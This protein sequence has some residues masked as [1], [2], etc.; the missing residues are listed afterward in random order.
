MQA[1]DGRSW[2]L[3]FEPDGFLPADLGADPGA[4]AGVE[5]VLCNSALAATTVID[6]PGLDSLTADAGR[7]TEELLGL[8][9]ASHR[10][11][12]G[13][14]A[15]LFLVPGLTRDDDRR[16]R[17]M[18]A[19]LA[20]TA[21]ASGF[22]PA[23][24]LAVVSRADVLEGPDPVDLSSDADP[25]PAARE[26]ADRYAERLR[27]VAAG[28]VPVA[29]LLAEAA[30]AALVTERRVDDLRRLAA[31]DP[32]EREVLLLSADLFVTTP[33]PGV[34]EPDRATLLDL[35]G[36]PG[37]RRCLSWIDHGQDR[38]DA[39]TKHLRAVSGVERLHDTIRTLFHAQADAIA[40]H[41]ALTALEQLSFAP[42]APRRDA[43]YRRG[44]PRRPGR[45][46]AARA[47]RP[48]PVDPW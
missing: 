9:G 42:G 37:V 17:S 48:R 39:I 16:L 32:D 2:T 40:A 36:L 34:S 12:R 20:S 7:R 15:V 47:R 28:V 43:R 41:R 22:T 18:A 27:G 26:L 38:A 4:V 45:A 1:R 29:G 23:T 19:A 25:W 21:A 46:A 24:V 10:A 44:R 3:P 14:D 35:L 11:L 6:T 31:L 5:V 8:D 30:E 33:V 13:A